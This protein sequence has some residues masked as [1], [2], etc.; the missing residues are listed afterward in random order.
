MINKMTIDN[1]TLI[2][3]ILRKKSEDFQIEPFVLDFLEIWEYIH[4]TAKSSSLDDIREILEDI[5]D[6]YT[7]P[8]YHKHKEKGSIELTEAWFKYYLSITLKWRT[9]GRNLFPSDLVAYEICHHKK[10]ALET[11]TKKILVKEIQGNTEALY[12]YLFPLLNNFLIPLDDVNVSI[13]KSL[14]VIAK[15]TT[16][17][18]KKPSRL[19]FARHLKMSTKTFAR[20]MKTIDFLQMVTQVSFCD[21]ARL[22]YETTLLIHSNPFPEEYN[23]YLLFSTDLTAG[24]FSI[25]QIP[26]N[27]PR[28]TA[29]LH[30]RLE[31]LTHQQMT[32]RVSSWNL[33]QL[34]SGEERWREPPSSLY[35]EPKVFHP[36]PDLEFSLVPPS[37]LFRP[38]TPADIKI[39]DF[40]SLK[41][42]FETIGE[43]S[44]E[45]DISR[46]EVS[47]RLQEYSEEKLLVLMYS[48][49]K[50]GLDLS[51]LF[52]ISTQ[53]RDQ[54]WV[55][56][57][58]SFPRVD[59]FYQ[60]KDRPYYYFGFLKLPNKWLKSFA[61]QVDLIKQDSE[62]KFYYKIASAADFV[63]WGIS[64]AETY[65]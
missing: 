16:S 34:A 46:P 62:I 20:R 49:Y 41:G 63:R 27:N 36:S 45:I 21:M 26:L 22:G 61:R 11:F 18:F 9:R 4:E 40:I 64:L 17:V 39:I 12:E 28:L 19:E 43:L 42:S 48:Y 23:R 60:K 35:G 31:L 54:P 1:Q 14:Q 47:N 13:L 30:D 15:H 8:F 6:N 56:N 2:L 44:Q 24:R 29:E 5:R 52:F 57:L 3:E 59:V 25:V 65:S 51:L 33:S 55:Q 38:L 58:L 10:M 50:I 53:N 37:I 7:L 32:R